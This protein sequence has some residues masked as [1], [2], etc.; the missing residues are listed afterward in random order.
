[1]TR[2][3]HRDRE[4]KYEQTSNNRRAPIILTAE[5]IAQGK[6][7]Y[8]SELEI[9]GLVRNLSPQ[10]WSFTHLTCLYLND[11]NLT[12]LSP[13]IAKLQHL[14]LLDLS[15]NK[16][17]SLP[18]EIGEL[19]MLHELYLNHNNLRQL[20]YELG[21][22]FQLQQLALKG[23]PLTQELLVIYNEQNGVQKLLTYLLDNL[24]GRFQDQY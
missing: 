14:L 10:L 6:E 4:N 18:A 13:E 19:I 23:N 8:W 24:Q 20:P 16:L 3:G 1:M 17:R 7:S 22:L 11:N 15:N 12:K 21:R 5:D 9:T 2:P